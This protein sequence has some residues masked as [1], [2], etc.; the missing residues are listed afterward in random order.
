MAGRTPALQ[1][2]WH[3]SEKLQ[4]LK[5]KNSIFTEHHVARET[6]LTFIELTAH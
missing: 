1:Q 4:H 2:N 3:S 5:E 6:L